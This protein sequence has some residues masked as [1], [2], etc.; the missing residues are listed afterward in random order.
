MQDA[1]TVLVKISSITN[2]KLIMLLSSKVR[3]AILKFNKKKFN[4]ES[5]FVA[6]EQFQSQSKLKSLLYTYVNYGK[7]FHL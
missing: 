2:L 7:Y 3:S 5:F 1:M 6:L 4:L